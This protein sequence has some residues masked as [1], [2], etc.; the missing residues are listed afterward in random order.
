MLRLCVLVH[1]SS[2][3]I[4]YFIKSAEKKNLTR[5]KEGRFSGYIAP[6]MQRF[7]H[8]T[9][10]TCKPAESTAKEAWTSKFTP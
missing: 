5:R 9:N 8:S 7:I 10:V 3:V 1:M 2:K 4:H 6:L